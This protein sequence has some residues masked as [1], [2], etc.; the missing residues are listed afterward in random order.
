MVRIAAR[1]PREAGRLTDAEAIR[2]FVAAAAD[3]EPDLARWL[4]QAVWA[5]LPAS[6][7]RRVRDDL[8]REA[9]RRLP[10]PSA[11]QKAH[12]LSEL[13]R[14][15]DARPGVSTVA[16]LVALAV[17]V[18]RPERRDRDLS[19]S[20]AFRILSSR[21]GVEM[22]VAGAVPSI[23]MLDLFEGSEQ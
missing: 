7:R 9:G 11:W 2:R 5:G 8:L 3:L 4:A 21:L 23:S 18:Y 15:P 14:C 12:R 17:A 10:L 6:R 19:V 20:Q 22:E 13:A 16:G 1:A